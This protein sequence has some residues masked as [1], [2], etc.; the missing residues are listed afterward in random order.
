MEGSARITF[1]NEINPGKKL[2]Q[3]ITAATFVL[4]QALTKTSVQPL[5]FITNA[6]KV[7]CEL[8]CQGND[9]ARPLPSPVWGKRFDPAAFALI[10]RPVNAV[11]PGTQSSTTV[12]RIGVGL[13][14]KRGVRERVWQYE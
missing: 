4:H 6:S 10:N 12:W 1:T 14:R 11:A 3:H 8:L 9:F 13:Y 7:G 2:L 5:E